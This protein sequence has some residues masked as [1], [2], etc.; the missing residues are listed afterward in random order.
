MGGA[1]RLRVWSQTDHRPPASFA[2][3]TATVLDAAPKPSPS[4][5]PPLHLLPTGS[6]SSPRI[7]AAWES[8]L[9]LSTTHTFPAAFPRSHPLAVANSAQSTAE[10]QLPPPGLDAAAAKSLAAQTRKRDFQEWERRCDAAPV[11]SYVPTPR[12]KM[13]PEKHK[14]AAQ[15]GPQL[16]ATAQRIVPV[17]QPGANAR[18]SSTTSR[19]GITLVFSHANGF[20]KEVSQ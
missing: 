17:P 4:A 19:E 9:W 12:E 1:P 3:P 5:L 15:D 8:T 14:A 11:E 20:H 7:V 6:L 18:A 13:G 16:W 10:P 2:L